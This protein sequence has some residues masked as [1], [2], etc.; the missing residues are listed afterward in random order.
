MA[1]PI[2]KS[3]MFFVKDPEDEFELYEFEAQNGKVAFDDPEAALK[4]PPVTGTR[5]VFCRRCSWH[6]PFDGI[7]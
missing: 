5:E 2:C 3:E 1:C 4:A 6:G 7:K